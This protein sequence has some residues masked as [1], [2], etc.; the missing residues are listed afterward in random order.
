MN[1]R[2]MMRKTRFYEKRRKD[3]EYLSKVVFEYI[4]EHHYAP[5]I[6]ELC[7]IMNKKSTSTISL[8]LKNAREL[9]YIDYIDNEP[10]TIVLKKY[11]YVLRKRP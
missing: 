11:E 5:S 8:K 3:A 9:G 2:E 10:R 6:R 1:E 7:E 4:S